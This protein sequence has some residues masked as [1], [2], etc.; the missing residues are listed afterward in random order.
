MRIAFFE[1]HD[2][3]IPLLRERLAGHETSFHPEKAQEADLGRF[4]DVEAVSVFI[5]SRMAARVLESLP[6]L[7]FIATRSTGVDHIDCATCRGRGIE[8]ATRRGDRQAVREMQVF[9][10]R[11]EKTN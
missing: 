11:L 4:Q 1:I 3:E 6:R 2:W 10:R 7:R 8:V 5:Y 9:V